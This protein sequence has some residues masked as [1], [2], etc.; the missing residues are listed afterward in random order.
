MIKRLIQLA[1]LVASFLAGYVA[2]HEDLLPFLSD[3]LPSA[4]AAP[5]QQE[6][7]PPMNPALKSTIKAGTPGAHHRILDRLAGEW[8]GAFT[9]RMDPEAPPMKVEGTLKRTWILDGRFL[10]EEVVSDMGGRTFKG[11]GILGFDN[12]NGVF[13]TLWMDNTGTNIL[14][15]TGYWDPDAQRLVTQGMHRDAGMG[16]I[17][18]TRS[19]IEM[20]D[21]DRHVTR[22]YAVDAHGREYLSFEGVAERVKK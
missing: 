19:R 1:L 7:T 14:H 9:L 22:M 8:K 17:V 18:L 11:L 4:G 12:A 5:V 6:G 21:P 15:E 10:K 3:I 2:G 13:E 16:R 20:S